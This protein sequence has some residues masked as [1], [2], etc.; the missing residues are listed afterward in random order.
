MIFFVT[1]SKYWI[2][3]QSS[4]EKISLQFLKKL[5]WGKL[6]EENLKRVS[7]SSS[8]YPKNFLGQFFHQQGMTRK[9]KFWEKSWVFT[10][11]DFFFEFTQSDHFAKISEKKWKNILYTYYMYMKSDFLHKEFYPKRKCMFSCENNFYWN[12]KFRKLYPKN[13]FPS[14]WTIWYPVF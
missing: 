5:F 6:K 13:L 8:S 3:K 12:E 9:I 4:R 1:L 7:L 2:R 14:K 11:T 10:F